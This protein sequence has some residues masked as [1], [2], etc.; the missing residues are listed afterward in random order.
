VSDQGPG[1]LRR[2]RMLRP[3]EVGIMRTEG[4]RARSHGRAVRDAVCWLVAILLLLL[5]REEARIVGRF[6]REAGATRRQ[7]LLALGAA[8]LLRVGRFATW[9]VKQVSRCLPARPWLAEVR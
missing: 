9:D 5:G 6:A 1:T 4:R 2:V 3:E 7:V 8:R